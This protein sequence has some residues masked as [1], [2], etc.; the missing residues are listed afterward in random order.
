MTTPEIRPDEGP[1]TLETLMALAELRTDALFEIYREHVSIP[2]SRLIGPVVQTG[3]PAE[4]LYIVRLLAFHALMQDLTADS[5]P[6]RWARAK[7][8]VPAPVEHVR[9]IFYGSQ[10]R[11]RKLLGVWVRGVDRLGFFDPVNLV[12]VHSHYNDRPDI[13]EGVGV[14]EF[15]VR[16]LAELLLDVLYDKNQDKK[17]GGLWA[18]ETLCDFIFDPRRVN[19]S[20]RERITREDFINNN[21]AERRQTQRRQNNEQP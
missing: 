16:A 14:F 5:L 12:F 19:F 8:G 20:L 15:S 21:T 2:G 7:D 3:I 17:G 13:V 4:P 11:S 10:T 1:L 18:L 9:G 6:L